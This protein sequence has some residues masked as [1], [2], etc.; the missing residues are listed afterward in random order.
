MQ[1]INKLRKINNIKLL[2]VNVNTYNI[3]LKKSNKL[4]MQMIIK[5]KKIKNSIENK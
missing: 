3:Y 1:N 4:H 5:L 2:K